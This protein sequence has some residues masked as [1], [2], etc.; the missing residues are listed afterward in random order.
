M[1]T[2]QA[3]YVAS[4]PVSWLKT[5]AEYPPKYNLN[6]VAPVSSIAMTQALPER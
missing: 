6:A 4:R 5:M 1:G 2:E 3:N